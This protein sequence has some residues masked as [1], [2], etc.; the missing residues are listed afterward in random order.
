MK[1]QQMET[2][3]SFEGKVILFTIVSPDS[4]LAY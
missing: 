2:E 1:E 3:G 4:S